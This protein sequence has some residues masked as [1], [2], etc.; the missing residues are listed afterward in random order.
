LPPARQK[1]EDSWLEALTGGTREIVV[2]LSSTAARVFINEAAQDIFGYSAQELIAVPAERLVHPEERAELR[3]AL[4][5]LM[6]DGGRRTTTLRAKHRLGH[7]F[8]LEVTASNYLGDPTVGMIVLHARPVEGA[9][10]RQSAKL[11]TRAIFHK[12]V[13]MALEAARKDTEQHFGVM[14]IEIEQYK[15]VLGTYGERA[16]EQLTSAVWQGLSL[17]LGSDDLLLRLAGGEFALLLPEVATPQ[18]AR[19]AADMTRKAGEVRVDLDEGETVSATVSA[20]IA[21]SKRG[22]SRAEEL[23]RDATAAMNRSRSSRSARVFHTMMRVEDTKYLALATG[24]KA[25]LDRGEFRVHYQPIVSIESS[26][27]LGFEALVRWQHPDRGLVSPLDFIPIAE[28]TGL[29]WQLGEWVL[30]TACTVVETWNRKRPED[31]PL[32]V[33]VNISPVQLAQGD[34]VTLVRETLEDTGLSEKALKLEVTESAV[35]DR[36]VDA[37]GILQK[38]CDMGVRLSLDDFGTGYSSF[39]YLHQLPYHTLKIDRSFVNRIDQDA[40]HRAIVQAI[41]SLAHGLGLEVVAEGV[42]TQAH[43]AVLAELGCEL[44]QGYLYSK[45]L[46]GAAA[47]QFIESSLRSG[48]D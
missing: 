44:G 46:D 33:A 26:A 12:R 5:A 43:R 42:E 1:T 3:A 7:F 11:S 4:M 24:M 9:T 6:K 30:K 21:T 29:I 8:A 41:V 34:L 38:I 40:E 18:Q 31:D 47:A 39:S 20:G 32:F 22:Y 19:R 45:P 37:K 2:L 28:E 27:L 13:E 25:G 36:E 14:T 35:L 23:V 10:S 48:D 15:R 17:M 16:A